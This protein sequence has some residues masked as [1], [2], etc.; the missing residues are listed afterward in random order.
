MA[1]ARRLHA[2]VVAVG[3]VIDKVAQRHAL[4]LRVFQVERLETA[5]CTVA[6]G[7]HFGS[8]F[9]DGKVVG[10]Y[11]GIVAPWASLLEFV[12]ELRFAR[13]EIHQQCH[14]GY[15]R[16]GKGEK[17]FQAKGF[18]LI[19]VH[20]A[21]GVRVRLRVPF[22]ATVSKNQSKYTESPTMAM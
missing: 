22:E 12:S 14:D 20:K 11:E 10:S 21:E 7:F 1:Q 15:Q 8:G 17:S 16:A 4:H 13:K 3:Y 9:I 5:Q 18:F 2:V 6:L 19:V